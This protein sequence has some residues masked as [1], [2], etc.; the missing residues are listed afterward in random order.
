MVQR[1][2]LRAIAL[3]LFCWPW[4][5]NPAAEPPE[6]LP[7]LE[8]LLPR[9]ARVAGLY[10]DQALK[11][12]CDETIY[13]TGARGPSVHKFKYIYR[14]SED[15][16][17]LLDYRTLRGRAGR[18]SDAAQERAALEHYGIPVYLLRAYSW[19]FVFS[20]SVQPSYGYSIEGE[21][22]VLG[23]PAV[24]LRFE[25]QPP[26]REGVNDWYGTAWIDRSTHQI[27]RIE[28][29][30]AEEREQELLLA[31]SIEAAEAATS[32]SSYRGTYTF[33]RYTTEFDVQQNGMRFPGRVVI[34]RSSHTVRGGRG[35]GGVSEEML[36]RI[37]QSYKKY[38]F[39]GVRTAEQIHSIV[40]GR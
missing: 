39:F 7:T 19:V 29:L 5:A 11:F 28:A 37:T 25:A 20:E 10:R 18:K 3:V 32:S 33:S 21:E 13:Y 27:L 6:P 15:E 8:Q 23:R 34:E 4:S 26:Y 22:V 38:R 31:K 35:K 36:F 1:K 30:R 12:T 16:A 14:Y 17:K 24:R 40:E 9:M 2:L